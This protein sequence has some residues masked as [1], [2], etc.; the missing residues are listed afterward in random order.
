MITIDGSRLSGSGTIVR[1]ALPFAALSEQSVRITNIRANRTKPGLRPQHLTAV[2]AI[3]TITG[4]QLH[5]D[6]KGATEISFEPG[7]DIRGGEFAWDIG[8]AG[9]TTMLAMSLLPLGLFAGS[10]SYHRITGGLFQ[11][12]APTAYH[13]QYVLVPQLRRMGIEVEINIRRPGYFPRGG[14]ILDVTVNPVRREIT[15][16]RIRKPGEFGVV[17]GISLASHLSDRNVA[18]RMARTCDEKLWNA[19]MRAHLEIVDDQH[20]VPAYEQAAPQPGAALAIWCGAESG[21]LLGA[22]MAGARGRPAEQIGNNVAHSLVADMNS[23]AT[24]DRHLADQLIPF[25]ALAAGL[26]EYRVP[27][28]TDHVETRLWLVS[29]LLGAD[30]DLSG[31]SIRIHGV[32]YARN[33]VSKPGR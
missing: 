29:H 5:G 9:S 32:G 31:E 3:A 8:T 10:S 23:G 12:Y 16:F 11:D 30:Y 18:Q 15:P 17:R 1:D 27:V 22:D 13:M 20:D 2:R 25:A 6:R 4:G 26:S 24:T 7:D 14:G 33:E 19:G 28:V 21:A